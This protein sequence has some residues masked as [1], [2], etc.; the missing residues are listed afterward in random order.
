V[1]P[2]V[3]FEPTT[4]RLR[5]GCAT[6]TPLGLAERVGVKAE[7]IEGGWGR[8]R[9]MGLGGGLADLAEEEGSG[10]NGDGGDGE[11]PQVVGEVVGG[12]FADLVET[13]ELVLDGAVVEVEAAHAEEDAG[14]G[15]PGWVRCGSAAFDQLD[16]ADD[17]DGGAEEVEEAVGDERS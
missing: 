7:C 10:E 13:E 9:E 4:F 2:E 17:Q 16:E 12:A 8:A 11:K 6:T 15:D 14:E 3:G 1:E 5:V